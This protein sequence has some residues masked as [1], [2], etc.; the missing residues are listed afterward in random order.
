MKEE[1]LHYLWKYKLYNASNLKTVN[2]ETLEI[3]NSGLHNLDAGPDFFNGKVKIDETIWAGNI[4][5]HV[6]SSDWLKHNHQTDKAYNNVVLH[7]VYQN[8]KPVLDNNNQPIPTLEL[9]DIIDQSRYEKY[10]DLIAS[11]DWI[12]C[13]NQIKLVDEFIINTWLN[14]LVVERLERKSEE[15]KTTLLQNKNDWE[16]TFY[17]Y[18]FKYFGLKVNAFPFEQLAKNTPLKIIEKHNQLIS[19]EALFYGQGGFL[20]AELKDEYH[21]KLLKE[22]QFLKAKFGLKMIDKS[23]WKLLRLRPANFP[24]IRISQLS[25]LLHQHPRL[26]SKIIGAKTVIEIQQY[27]KVNASKYWDNHYQFGDEAIPISTKNLGINTINNIIINVV[28]PFTFVYGK[29]KQDEALVETALSLLE[30]TKPETNII[31]KNWKELGVKSTNAMQT[32]SLIELKNNYCSP[33]KCLNCSI[34]NNILQQ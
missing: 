8:D 7:V 32:Q 6:K 24:T 2:G 14:R 19:I 29:F 23:L 5:I 21:Q 4:E 17:Q 16:Q 20:E 9:K 28:V 26:F 13:G 25:N 22:Y 12:P 27:F 33:K 3:L 34:G 31:V 10:E 15:I 11:K 18:L 30:K 1:F